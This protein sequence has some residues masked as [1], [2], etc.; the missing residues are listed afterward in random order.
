MEQ[1]TTYSIVNANGNF[2]PL[3]ETEAI[4]LSLNSL[5]NYQQSSYKISQKEMQQWVDNLDSENKSP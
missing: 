3:T 1:Q 5:Q 4:D 2:V